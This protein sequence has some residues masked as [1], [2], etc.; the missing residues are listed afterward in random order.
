MPCQLPAE[1]SSRGRSASESRRSREKGFAA[2]FG[3]RPATAPSWSSID[4]NGRGDAI[5]TMA[6]GSYLC[7]AAA[8]TR[9][10]IGARRR[11]G[12]RVKSGDGPIPG[13]VTPA[14]AIAATKNLRRGGPSGCPTRR[15]GLPA[16]QYSAHRS[17]NCCSGL[18]R[19]GA[20]GRRWARS[21]DRIPGR[22]SRSWWSAER[23]CRGLPTGR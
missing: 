14:S 10:H 21:P 22:G 13:R 15:I 4:R 12:L 17:R 18:R 7:L 8:S 11:N 9:R 19:N 5:W 23:R 20:A 1:R 16:G 3:D 2:L 6:C